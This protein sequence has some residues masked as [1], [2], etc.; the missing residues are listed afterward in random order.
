VVLFKTNIS[1]VRVRKEEHKTE[2][3][4]VKNDM[5]DKLEKSVSAM[6]VGQENLENNRSLNQAL[7]LQAAK[8]AAGPQAKLKEVARVRGGT[9]PTPPER[10]RDERPVC[11]RCRKPGQ[12]RK[13]CRQRPHEKKSQSSEARRRPPTSP[14]SPPRFT[15][16]V[17]AKGTEVI[18]LS[19]GWIQEKPSRVTIDT[20][21]FV[22]VARPDIT[23]GLPERKPSRQYVLQTGVRSR[24]RN[25]GNT[26]V[27]SRTV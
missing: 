6:S 23:V 9:P 13:E 26:T 22:T 11:W 25:G 15:L 4:A 3:S 18:L 5:K 8:A 10:R 7:R 12:F 1:A 21:A 16:N 19:D 27:N 2:E 14:P 20:G 24:I 17:L